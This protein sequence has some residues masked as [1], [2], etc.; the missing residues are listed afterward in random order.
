MENSMKEYLVFVGTYTEGTSPG[1]EKSGGIY[2]Y[3]MDAEDGT[4]SL[5]HATQGIVNPSFL[6]LHP[7]RRFL[8]AVN[9]TVQFDGHPGGGVSAFSI[10]PQ[11]GALT[12]LN[13]QLSQGAD[14]CHIS[15]EAAGKFVLVANYSGGSLS[16]LPIEAD[17]RLRPAVEVI[18]HT[19]SGIDPHRQEGPHVH[20]V[21]LDPDNQFLITADL[22]LDKLVLYRLELAEG[23]LLHQ[24]DLEVNVQS[25]AGPRHLDFHPSGR[26]VYLINELNS[27]LIAY[28]Y[29]PGQGRLS[30]IQTVPT[31]PQG[32]QGANWP[33]DIHVAPSGRFVYGSNRLHDSLVIFAVDQASGRLT[34]VGH[35]STGGQTP[36]NFAIDPS[37]KF[38]LAAN[39]NSG[40]I[41]VFRID[42]QTGRLSPTGQILAVPSPV[43][44]KFLEA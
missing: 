23:K 22:G 38:L 27:T 7:N 15:V 3:R 21:N 17:G 16:L 11:T 44:I 4:F 10:H 42:E 14:P 2:V 8:Y 6:A 19:G 1:V 29:N 25:G 13:Q 32:F 30:E 39:Q 5:L 37:G 9:E 24:P 40:T 31:L 28:T 33:A 26:F 12:L 36:R 20:S 41:V 35:T 43:C 18:Q 34:Y